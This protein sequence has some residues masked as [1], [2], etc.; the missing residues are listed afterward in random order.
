M[1][2]SPCVI[3]VIVVGSRAW[4]ALEGEGGQVHQ[5]GGWSSV[6]WL[7]KRKSAKTKKKEKIRKHTSS[8]AVHHFLPDLP[9]AMSRR[10]PEVTER[11]GGQQQM[12][13]RKRRCDSKVA[14][15]KTQMKYS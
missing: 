1:S 7:Q 11:K 8:V 5:Q 10:V 3:L 4:Q 9:N 6:S 14:M 12:R 2:A 13:K 15:K